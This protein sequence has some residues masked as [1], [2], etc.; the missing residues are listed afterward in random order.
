MHS[1][2]SQMPLQVWFVAD[3]QRSAY[4]STTLSVGLKVQGYELI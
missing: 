2:C 3:E 4:I 1:A